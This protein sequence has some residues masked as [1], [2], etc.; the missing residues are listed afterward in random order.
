MKDIRGKIRQGYVNGVLKKWSGRRDSNP[1]PPDPQSGA[2]ARLRYV[3]TARL[4]PAASNSG[5]GLLSLSTTRRRSPSAA[6]LLARGWHA[7]PRCGRPERGD[8]SGRHVTGFAMVLCGEELE[9]GTKAALHCRQS[10][11][12]VSPDELVKRHPGGHRC[13]LFLETTP[14]A[15]E[16]QSLHQQQVLNPHGLL[17]VGASV[18][19]GAA[20]VLGDAEPWELGLPSTQ[21]VR[22]H[23]QQV[24]DLCRSE[25]RAV[26]YRYWCGTLGHP[27]ENPRRV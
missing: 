17:D 5:D 8:R 20:R 4:Y 18:D 13:G 6:R 14:S 10:I 16:R 1:R 26:R 21:Y 12:G 25:Q 22:L 7:T 2:L 24:A 11:S 15:G 27:E 19:P 23:L 9:D 3:P